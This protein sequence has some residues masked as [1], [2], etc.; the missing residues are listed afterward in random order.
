MI[1]IPL[2][3]RFVRNCLPQEMCAASLLLPH[4]VVWFAKVKIS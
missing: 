4:G 2:S 3:L 1:V